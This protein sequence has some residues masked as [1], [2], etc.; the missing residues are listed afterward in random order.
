MG[1][2][3][4]EAIERILRESKRTG[5]VDKAALAATTRGRVR[6]SGSSDG[7]LIDLSDA[8]VPTVAGAAV[9]TVPLADESLDGV[10][11]D[12]AQMLEALAEA[13]LPMSERGPGL[14][15]R[16]EG[17]QFATSKMRE[18]AVALVDKHEQAQT[19]GDMV[20]A[21]VGVPL[22]DGAPKAWLNRTTWRCAAT[23]A[24]SPAASG[25]RCR[26]V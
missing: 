8:G 14:R 5:R 3:Y 2:G 22:V 6:E 4:I 9:A 10:E 20:R 19:L 1:D 15:R 16:L 13:G 17:A 7:E 23:S 24:R 21:Y 11:R 26:S 12:E 18:T 25:S